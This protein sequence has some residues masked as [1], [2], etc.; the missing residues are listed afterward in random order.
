MIG[1]YEACRADPEAQ[2]AR[3]YAFLGLPPFEPPAARLRGEVNPST[4]PRFDPPPALRRALLDGYVSDIE[5]LPAL[6]PE[7]DLALWPTA[8]EL[9]LA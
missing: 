9:G 7:L 6:A 2:L 1:Q 3:T 8:R 5:Q 4:G